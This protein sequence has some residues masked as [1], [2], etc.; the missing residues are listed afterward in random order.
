MARRYGIVFAL[1]YRCSKLRRKP[2]AK[3]SVGSESLRWFSPDLAKDPSGSLSLTFIR[4]DVPSQVHQYCMC[5]K[6]RTFDPMLAVEHTIHKM[7]FCFARISTPYS[8]EVI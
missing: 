3:L 1:Y 5:L 6:R 2:S 8:T 4:K 7:E